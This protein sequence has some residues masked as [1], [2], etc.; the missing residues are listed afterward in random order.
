MQYS[1]KLKM[2]MEEIK[3]ILKKHD[4]A[5]MVI[6]HTPGFTEYLNKIDPSYSILK[7]KDGEGFSFNAHSNHFGGDKEKR[8]KAAAD[9]RNM[10]EHFTEFT[11]RQFMMY[12]QIAKA[13]DERFGKW[14]QEGGEHT[15]HT[16]QNN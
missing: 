11:G 8:D 5:G 14:D 4:I 15:S 13:I 6:L 10:I 9:T 12:N 7:I 2:A 1:P 16:Q 3:A